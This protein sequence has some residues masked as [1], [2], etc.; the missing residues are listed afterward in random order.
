MFMLSSQRRERTVAKTRILIVEDEVIT[1][2][3]IKSILEELG[4]EAPGIA[5]SGNE[6]ISFAE[7]FNPDLILMDIVLKGQMDGTEAAKEILKKKHV[8]IIFLTAYSDD[9][10]F[11]RA[12]E[13]L[14]YGYVTKPFGTRQVQMVIE[15]ALYKYKMEKKPV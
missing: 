3:D 6:A 5:N 12:K 14:P 4:Y 13:V 11:T 10:T 8:P 2:M 1:A 15:M 9:E 7:Q